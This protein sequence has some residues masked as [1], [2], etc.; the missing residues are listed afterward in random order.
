MNARAERLHLGVLVK[1]LETESTPA[2]NA[3]DEIVDGA[4][5]NAISESAILMS[6]IINALGAVFTLLLETVRDVRHGSPSECSKKVIRAFHI[7]VGHMKDA[8]D[9]LIM[10]ASGMAIGD[11]IGPVLTPEAILIMLM[12]RLVCGVFGNGNIDVINIYEAS[13]EYLVS[14]I[15]LLHTCD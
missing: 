3:Q 7:T 13:L 12:E 15:T 4:P 14:D 10:E 6:S 1:R 8:R 11:H 9:E 5:D 2:S